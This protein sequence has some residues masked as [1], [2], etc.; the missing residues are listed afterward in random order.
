M[1]DSRPVCLRSPFIDHRTNGFDS[2]CWYTVSTSHVAGAG[3]PRCGE[4]GALSAFPLPACLGLGYLLQYAG[5]D[6]CEVLADELL[7]DVGH[8]GLRAP[9][10]AEELEDV[11][12][13][14]SD[15]SRPVVRQ[16]PR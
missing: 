3:G 6:G 7:A 2:S 8:D 11:A 4:L 13:P 14:T 1:T 15:R 5:L 16:A 9:G 12:G 10:R